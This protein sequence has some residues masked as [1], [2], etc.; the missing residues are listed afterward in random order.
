MEQNP[1]QL[2]VHKVAQSISKSLIEDERKN[3]YIASL[4]I[5]N[6]SILEHAYIL[7]ERK[8]TNMD[9][10]Y[11]ICFAADME[12]KDISL[13]FNIEPASVR[14]V[15]YRIKKKFQEKNTFKFLI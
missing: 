10:K 3:A 5:L 4:I 12:S 14:T 8:I 2:I 15:R 9:M 6:T 7:S 1:T 13:I 11:L